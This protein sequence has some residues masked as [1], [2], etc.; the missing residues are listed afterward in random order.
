MQPDNIRPVAKIPNFVFSDDISHFQ[1]KSLRLRRQPALEPRRFHLSHY[2]RSA[3]QIP[4]FRC[5]SRA[6]AGR[7]CLFCRKVCGFPAD[8][9]GPGAA[10]T[11]PGPL[12]Q[13]PAPLG[14]KNAGKPAFFIPL[15]GVEARYCVVLLPQTCIAMLAWKAWWILI[16]C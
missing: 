3:P 8:F 11:G 15:R 12:G 2:R 5:P 13:E 10:R 4:V 6:A 9:S 14:S 16:G 7:L 1:S